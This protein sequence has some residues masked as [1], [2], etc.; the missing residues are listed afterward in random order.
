MRSIAVAAHPDDETLWWG[1]LILSQPGDWTIV[2]CSIPRTDPVRAWLFF[3]ACERLGARGRLIPVH[4][5]G[6]SEMLQAGSMSLLSCL[7]DYDRIVTHGR[8][9]EYGH[10]HHVALSALIHG[11]WGDKEIWSR[12]PPQEQQFDVELCLEPGQADAKLHALKAYEHVLPYEG[13]P[14]TKW[15]ALLQRYCERGPHGGWQF[16][17]ERYRVHRPRQQLG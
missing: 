10:P 12:V 14:M 11:N 7:G 1:G 2:C 5:T 16:C 9:G 4:E 8:E 15:E 3:E 13:R 6:P 17:I